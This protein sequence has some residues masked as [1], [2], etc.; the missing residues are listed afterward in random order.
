MFLQFTLLVTLGFAAQPENQCVSDQINHFSPPHAKVYTRLL[1]RVGN[2]VRISGI[3]QEVLV[4][5]KIQIPRISDQNQ[6]SCLNVRLLN[7]G[8]QLEIVDYLGEVPISVVIEEQMVARE[9]ALANSDVNLVSAIDRFLVRESN[10]SERWE[11]WKSL[12]TGSADHQAEWLRLGGDFFSGSSE[13]SSLIEV[14]KIEKAASLAGLHPFNSTWISSSDLAKSLGL[15]A[16]P[17]GFISEIRSNLLNQTR[18][19]LNEMLKKTSRKSI[20]TPVGIG[21]QRKSV[22]S[23]WGDPQKV[24]WVRID[25]HMIEQ[26]TYQDRHVRLINGRV[27][28]LK[29]SSDIS[30]KSN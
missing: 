29:K 6:D 14:S 4:S 11:L 28:E 7:H 9:K 1:E 24:D 2:S 3:K 19:G 16:T 15:V 8:D 26:W 12:R 23:A 25:Q 20:N 30:L 21:S 10:S 5:H 13:L 17:H 18:H 27:Y 22:R